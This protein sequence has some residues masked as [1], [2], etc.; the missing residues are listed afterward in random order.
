MRNKPKDAASKEK[1]KAAKEARQK[2]Y[3]AKEEPLLYHEQPQPGKYT[4]KSTKPME[5]RKDLS[6]AYSPGVAMPCIEIA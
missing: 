3:A 1:R 6:L 2:E 5:N 4:I